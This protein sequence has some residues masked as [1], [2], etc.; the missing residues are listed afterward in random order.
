MR[1]LPQ[2]ALDG[3]L[4]KPGAGIGICQINPMEWRMIDRI[5][6][7]PE[8]TYQKEP[9]ATYRQ[10]LV[11]SGCNFL[12]QWIPTNPLSI[13][14]H[15]YEGKEKTATTGLET[16][17]RDGIAIDS[18]EAGAAH[19]E[20][21][22]FPALEQA[23]ASFTPAEWAKKLLDSERQI[24][25]E[26]GPEILKAPYGSPFGPVPGFAY[27]TY[28]YVAYFMMAA[29]FPELIARHFQLQARLARLRNTVAARVIVENRLPPYVRLDHDM[30]D[31]RGPLMNPGILE[32]VWFP[33]LARAIEP[34]VKA[35][36]TCVWH[37]DGNLMPMIPGLLEAG[38][39]GFQGFQY[40]FGM[41]YEKICNMKT[42]DG[43]DL[44][45]IGGVSVTQTLPLGK[46]ADVK[47]ELQW[48]VKY[49]P[50]HGLFLGASSSIAPGVP[51]E[52]LK[53]LVE[54]FHYYR[55]HGRK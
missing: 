3:I 25:A 7:V 21:K 5:A 33:E 50:K 11:N 29:L 39:A 14:A 13:G 34:L 53:T 12:D 49:G 48:L 19:L 23:I 36:I 30:A 26:V 32:A 27:G 16:I 24:Q 8:G 2:Q 17:V 52:N 47:R 15:G 22:A 35:G 9:V 37:C 6:G 45:I 46:P 41:D 38:I 54:G 43:N 10:M 40:E 18:P 4:G 31:G 28:G 51:W 55:Q 1:S 44:L 20:T 42:R